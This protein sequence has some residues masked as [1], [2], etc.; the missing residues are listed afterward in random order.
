MGE[1]ISSKPMARTAMESGS[2]GEEL[3]GLMKQLKEQTNEIK[4]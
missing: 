1:E 4:I 3:S 2:M